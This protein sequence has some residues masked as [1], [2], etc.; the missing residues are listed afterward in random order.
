MEFDHHY[1]RCEKVIIQ[2]VRLRYKGLFLYGTVHS[3]E[4]IIL[5]EYIT[6]HRTIK[7]YRKF[8]FPF[9]KKKKKN[10]D[11]SCSREIDFSFNL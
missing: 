4:K 9:I 11:I 6:S 2:N 10:N 8:I 3:V 5:L 7:C 1:I